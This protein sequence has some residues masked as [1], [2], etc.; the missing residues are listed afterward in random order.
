MIIFSI[1]RLNNK[2]RAILAASKDLPDPAL[3]FN[4]VTVLWRIFSFA[5]FCSSFN[6]ISNLMGPL[7]FLFVLKILGLGLFY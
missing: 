5:L 7:G 1:S 2:S 4:T 3:P 6:W